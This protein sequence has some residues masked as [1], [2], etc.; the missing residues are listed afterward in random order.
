M[1]ADEEVVAGHEVLGDCQPTPSG[2]KEDASAGGAQPGDRSGAGCGV[3]SGHRAETG[4]ADLTSIE[5]RLDLGIEPPAVGGPRRRDA[6][7]PVI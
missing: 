6:R 2:D 4:V 5:E 1:P 7:R 3:P